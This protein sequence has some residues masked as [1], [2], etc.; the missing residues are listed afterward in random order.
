V[1]IRSNDVS[2]RNQSQVNESNE[3]M[4]ASHFNNHENE[5]FKTLKTQEATN[6]DDQLLES[7]P[8]A[9]Y[10]ST[11]ITSAGK[12]ITWNIHVIFG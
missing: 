10:P 7:I 5:S 1:N 12:I 8:L 6:D 3:Q 2:F 11:N 9:L 4:D